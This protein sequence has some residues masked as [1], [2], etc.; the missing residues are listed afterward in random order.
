VRRFRKLQSDITEAENNQNWDLAL[1]HVGRLQQIEEE[2][3]EP[4]FE[5]STARL[6]TDRNR[7]QARRQIATALT[8]GARNMNAN[9]RTVLED[10]QRTLDRVEESA[11]QDEAL[12]GQ[13]AGPIRL[14]R[15]QLAHAQFLIDYYE[16][17]GRDISAMRAARDR[18]DTA[19]AGRDDINR[20]YGLAEELGRIYAQ[21]QTAVSD[22][23]GSKGITVV[24]GYDK[25]IGLLEQIVARENDTRFVLAQKASEDIRRLRDERKRLLLSAFTTPVVG[26]F[27]AGLRGDLERT[28][29]ERKK[30][31]DYLSLYELGVRE[32]RYRN[33]VL[34]DQLRDEEVANRMV[35]AYD[36]YDRARSD[37]LRLLLRNYQERVDEGVRTDTP[38]YFTRLREV[39]L[40]EDKETE[41]AIA[42]MRTQME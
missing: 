23:E 24:Q 29:A 30:W 32:N 34:V 35:E 14:L 26:D 13:L 41:R 1:R 19:Y 40:P 28:L 8:D 17:D 27:P 22:L 11:K 38:N 18:V 21:Y 36:R 10:S 2:I 7:I 12:A 37:L 20:R 3:K 4:V 42:S 5:N 6:R 39:T 31:F 9:P 25:A 33:L 15:S 16:Y